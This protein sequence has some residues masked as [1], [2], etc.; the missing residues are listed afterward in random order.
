MNT[1]SLNHQEPINDEM[2]E[3][4]LAGEPVQFLRWEHKRLVLRRVHIRG[5]Q[6]KV[7]DLPMVEMDGD[8]RVG[9]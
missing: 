8:L 3:R 1:G 6:V 4:M 7:R 2:L 5:S 9:S